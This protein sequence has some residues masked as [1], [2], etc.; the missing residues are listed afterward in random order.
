M[1]FIDY[2]TEQV[3][4]KYSHIVA[5]VKFRFSYKESEQE[6]KTLTFKKI[7]VPSLKKDETIAQLKKLEKVKSA[8]FVK[9]EG[10]GD[11]VIQLK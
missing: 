4:K 7:L 10:G 3:D 8:E 1:S 5:W 6:G 9:G 11:L 2:L